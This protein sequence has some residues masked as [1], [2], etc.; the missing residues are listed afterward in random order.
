MKFCN[1]I[2]QIKQRVKYICYASV[3]QKWLPALC[4]TVQ[5]FPIGIRRRKLYFRRGKR[6]VPRHFMLMERICLYLCHA[7]KA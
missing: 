1:T 6:D 3:S 4:L 7:K 2:S 5:G